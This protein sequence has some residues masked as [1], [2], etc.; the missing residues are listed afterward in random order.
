MASRGHS[1]SF[2]IVNHFLCG[3]PRVRL[4]I[5]RSLFQ[6]FIQNNASRHRY[7]KRFEVASH[8]NAE[9]YIGSLYQRRIHP[10]IFRT[11]DHCHRLPEIAIVQFISV[12]ISLAITLI[13]LRC[14]V[15]MALFRLLTR[16]T[17][18]L[19]M[20]PQMISRLLRSMRQCLYQE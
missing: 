9:Q 17:A 10:F 12:S 16:Q 11:H 2:S 8:R 20:H 1:T 3:F 4:N 15:S 5:Y 13:P 19:S 14:R 18:I 6:C 7:I